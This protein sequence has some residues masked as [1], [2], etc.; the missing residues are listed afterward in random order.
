MQK[1]K[2]VQVG[3]LA[4]RHEGK[5]WNAYFAKPGTMEGAL[6]IGS[7]AMAGVANNPKRHNAFLTMM[8]ELVCEILEDV[9]GTM[10]TWGAPE[11]APEHERAGHS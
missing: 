2:Q 8:T 3:R 6:H 5:M 9:S 10:P 7:I 1:D 11:L 4:M